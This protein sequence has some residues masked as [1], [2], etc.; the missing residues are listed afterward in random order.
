MITYFLSLY[1]IIVIFIYLCSQLGFD[2]KHTKKI[3]QK[4]LNEDFVFFSS[5][6][7][8]KTYV[9]QNLPLVEITL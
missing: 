2:K 9:S 5:I 4:F 7:S 6:I 1:I 3:G 8:V